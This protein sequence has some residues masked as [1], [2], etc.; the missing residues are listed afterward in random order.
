MA[1][2]GQGLGDPLAEPLDR[3]FNTCGGANHIG[4]FFRPENDGRPQ[5]GSFE[6]GTFVAG[7]FGEMKLVR[8][9]AIESSDRQNLA[10]LQWNFTEGDGAVVGV[11]PLGNV[12]IVIA[13][14][15]DFEIAV[16]IVVLV[17][18]IVISPS[19]LAVAVKAAGVFGS[20]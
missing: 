15:A 18:L 6:G 16:L 9:L 19:A 13:H 7:G 12:L 5:I 10:R 2:A 1:V 8:L 4:P 20:A 14:L 17:I 3:G 11:A